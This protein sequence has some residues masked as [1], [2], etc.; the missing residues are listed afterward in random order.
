MKKITL[1]FLLFLSSF[2]YSQE[3][4]IF[5]SSLHPLNVEQS[6]FF[7]L[8]NRYY[9]DFSIPKIV[10]NVY[11]EQSEISET[12]VE[13]ELPPNDCDDYLIILQS[14]NKRLDYEFYY[15]LGN[16]NLINMPL[17]IFANNDA[18]ASL[19]IGASKDTGSFVIFITCFTLSTGNPTS[20]AISSTSGSL[21]FS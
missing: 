14:D 18:A 16:G 12:Y 7:A 17:P 8:V 1:L 5:V 4:K 19:P 20:F 13:Y 10:S 9:S 11:N 21:P 2:V 3:K 6:Q 15:S